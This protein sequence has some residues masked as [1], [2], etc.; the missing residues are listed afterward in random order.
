MAGN[1]TSYGIPPVQFPGVG[2]F[3]GP[4][5]Q[6]GSTYGG[7]GDFSGS[8]D[9]A[10]ALYG[11][12]QPFGSPNS[13]DPFASGQG[14]FGL[15][16]DFTSTLSGPSSTSGGF[17][18]GPSVVASAS[19]FLG[20]GIGSGAGGV[21]DG[22]AASGTSTNGTA[23]SGTST[24]GGSCTGSGPFFGGSWNPLCIA[25]GT[26]CYPAGCPGSAGSSTASGTG[27]CGWTNPAACLAAVQGQIGDF[28][29]RAAVVVLGFIF[30]LAGL[31]MF[32]RMVP[33]VRHV[34]PNTLRP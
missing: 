20:G 13:S 8:A 10:D 5:G 4:T 26:G 1:L 22:T 16:P 18:G 28:A 12:F 11:S 3:A 6:S 34:V 2:T 32:G 27:T 31:F 21:G 17:G 29:T 33:F 19:S 15:N 14:G 9:A 25:G 30:V 7:F 24:A 23:A